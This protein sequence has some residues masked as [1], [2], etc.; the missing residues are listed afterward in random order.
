MTPNFR[1]AVV[2]D[3]HVALSHTIWDHPS[4]FH[5]VEVSIPAFESILEHLTQLDLDFLLLPGD[6]TQHGESENHQWLQERLAH[7]PFPT[8]VIPGNH[9]VPVLEADQQSIGFHDFPHYYRKFGYENTDKLYYTSHLLPGVRLIGLNSNNFNAKGEQIGCLDAEQLLWLEEVLAAAKDELVLVMV[10]H[11]VV[12]H[13]PNQSNHA[14]ASRYMA[15]NATQLLE[16]LQRY[17]VKL[18]F[19]GHLHVQDIAYSNGVYDITTGSLASYPHPYRIINFSEDLSGK[20]QLTITSHRVE[21]VPDFPNLQSYSRKWMGDRS[22][23]FMVRLL[24]LPPLS[25]PVSQAEQLAPNLREFWAEI[26]DGDALFD[27]QN[28]PQKVRDY[29]H[30]F[31]AVNSSGV[32]RLIDNNVSLSL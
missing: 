19:T 32:P 6:L 20:Q 26:A 11:N 18:V 21:S 9:D 15:A 10:H 2:S 16:I 17:G 8:Y 23:S 22:F 27:H 14:M 31:S 24:T 29:F 30:Q 28:F 4:R 1:F 13:L 3:L 7:L 12:E 5:L 25:L